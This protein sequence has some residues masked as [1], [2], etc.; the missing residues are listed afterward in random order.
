[1][2]QQSAVSL[3]RGT[4]KM[5]V[6]GSQD[7][8]NEMHLLFVS[9]EDLVGAISLITIEAIAVWMAHKTIVNRTIGN[10]F[11]CSAVIYSVLFSK[12]QPKQFC[13]YYEM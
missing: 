6:E 4:K 7:F 1:M 2:F 10:S 5:G 11:I 3:V 9:A 8:K 12:Q 13:T